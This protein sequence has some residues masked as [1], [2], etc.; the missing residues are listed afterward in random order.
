MGGGVYMHLT[1]ISVGFDVAKGRNADWRFQFGM[2]V[3]FK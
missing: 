3:T 1:L 2:G